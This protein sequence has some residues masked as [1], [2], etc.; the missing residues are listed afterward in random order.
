MSLNW[1]PLV[2]EGQRRRR[3]LMGLFEAGI[4][5]K[6]DPKLVCRIAA[7][8]AQMSVYDVDGI[9]KLAAAL[10]D[11]APRSASVHYFSAHSLRLAGECDRSISACEH[12]LTLEPDHPETKVLLGK[13]LVQTDRYEQARALLQRAARDNPKQAA[14]PLCECL[15][16]L[17]KFDEA[18]KVISEFGDPAEMPAG[19]VALDC[20]CSIVRGDRDRLNRL[21]DSSLISECD[22]QEETASLRE[23][24]SASI[25]GNSA[26][27]D[28]PA[29]TT[30]LKGRQASL[31]DLLDRPLLSEVSA[32][33]RKH[34]EAYVRD[35]RGHPYLQSFPNEP[36][37]TSWAVTLREGG[38][39]DSHCH[40]GGKLSGVFYVDVD[41]ASPRIGNDGAIEFWQ[42]PEKLTCGRKADT[43]SIRPRNGT[44]LIFPSYYYHRTIPHK[45]N[46]GRLSIAFDIV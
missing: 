33:I 29:R 41:K 6:L 40:P 20:V 2:S 39:Q 15:I 27:V 12:A 5:S 1:K 35:N 11:Y 44:M 17:G 18:A 38:F 23:R 16:R 45:G 9:R 31:H 43:K 4:Q 36:Q 19:L 46:R 24:L 32:L 7:D 8:I 22:S 21:H 34:V 42:P 3:A 25:K 37:I 28:E 10:L 30:T 26:L 14:V 13:V